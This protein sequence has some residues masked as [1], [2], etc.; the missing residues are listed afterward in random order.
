VHAVAAGGAHPFAERARRSREAVPVT[1]WISRISTKLAN[2]STEPSA[3]APATDSDWPDISDV[4]ARSGVPILLFIGREEPRYSLVASFAEQ[5]GARL[6]VLPSQK[7][8]V[9]GDLELLT[10]VLGFFE[11]PAA[12]AAEDLPPCLWSGSWG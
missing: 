8:T 11:D 7:S 6:I 1:T 3:L 5:S 10:R 4:V 2:A 12:A 9:D